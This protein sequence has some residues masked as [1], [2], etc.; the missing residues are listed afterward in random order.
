MS[1]ARIL[2]V[3]DERIVANDIRNTLERLGH[4][5]AAVV[6]SGEDA[7][8]RARELKPDLVLMDI[9]LGGRIDGIQAAKEIQKSRSIPIVFMTAHLDEPTLQRAKV[10]GPFGYVLKPFE[11]RELHTTVEIALYKGA[12]DL[13]LQEIDQL[14]HVTKSIGEFVV[15]TD[16]HGR[17]TY[18]NRAFLERF[19]CVL[20]DVVER[21]GEE[22]LSD[23]I[24]P[25]TMR[26]VI[27][28]TVH[29]G[30]SGDLLGRPKGGADFWMS[31]TT[32]LLTRDGHVLGA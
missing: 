19:G 30:W 4:T 16:T 23:V 7:V 10:T 15:I 5:V 11:E 31:L 9:T 20:E 32:S 14:A 24:S 26:G 29:G 21:R 2:V 3:E 27:R 18:A 28:G 6:S 25:D 17:I 8:A 22:F 1:S 13:R 12:A